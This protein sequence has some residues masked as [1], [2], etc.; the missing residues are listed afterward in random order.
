MMTLFILLSPLTPTGRSQTDRP[1]SF[2]R[3]VAIVL[4]LLYL[5][6]CEIITYDI[7]TI[8]YD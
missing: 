8:T 7:Y 4:A 3:H 2:N 6:L 1:A 5:Y